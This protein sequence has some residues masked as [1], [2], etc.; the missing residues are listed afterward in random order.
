MNL[1]AATIT[2][3]FIGLV[4]FDALHPGPPVDPTRGYEAL[5]P[6][7][8]AVPPPEFQ[9]FTLQRHEAKLVIAK[10][11]SGA[12]ECTTTL[13]GNWAAGECTLSPLTG[14]VIQVAGTGP[15]ST[16]TDFDNVPRLKTH[17]ATLG[18]RDSAFPLAAQ[19]EMTHG[20]LDACLQ[21]KAWA[22]ALTVNVDA[23]HLDFDVDGNKVSLPNGAIVT[24]SN[25][26]IGTPSVVQ[27]EHFF[28]HYVMRQNASTCT[29][30][31]PGTGSSEITC[32]VK[33]P[34][35]DHHHSIPSVTG[36]G[37]SVTAYP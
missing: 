32:R 15:F 13:N 5:V 18:A 20:T 37:C 2:I 26:P 27:E 28:W 7:A 23:Q 14:S 1:T 21:G 12:T 29:L 3:Y 35:L 8:T 36:V 4:N 24:I 11:P 10:W 6:L 19:L 16:T 9:T 30:P 31:L 17:C 22:A 33:Y 25:E 34:D